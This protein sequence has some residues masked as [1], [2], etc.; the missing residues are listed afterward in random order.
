MNINEVPEQYKVYTVIMSNR[1]EYEITGVQKESIVNAPTQWVDLPN[2]TSI[3]KSFAI[4]FKLNID[5]T[6]ENVRAHTNEI[7]NGIISKHEK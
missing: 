4:E 7:K 5:A 2:G 6:R 1:S 3:N